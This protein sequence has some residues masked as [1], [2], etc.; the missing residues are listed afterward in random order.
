V[1]A[2]AK[3]IYYLLASMRPQQWTKNLV[4]FAGLIFSRNFR[5]GVLVLHAVEAFLIFCVLSGVIYIVNDVADVE[6]DRRHPAKR[7]RAL[8]SGRLRASFAVP[9]A[10]VLGGAALY[11]AYRLGAEFLTVA[12]T[13]CALNL[14]YSF[15]LKRLVLLDVVS[16]SL[17]FVLRAIGGVEALRGVD[18]SIAISPWLLICT[19][20]LSLFLAFCKRRHELLTIEDAVNHRESLQE[21]SPAL[22]DQLVSITAGG[23]VLAYAIYT[24]WPETVEKFGT[25]DMVYTVPLV[26]TG[27][28]RY[29]YL[30]YN[31]QK[32][33]NPSDLL[34]HEKFLFVIVALWIV[35]VVAILGGF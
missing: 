30:V 15:G 33:G 20:F 3:Q 10:V 7:H 32:G 23:S 22:L 13:F 34:L 4:V 18:P 5:E 14:L 1:T 26:L 8:A 11:G 35:L 6:K 28:M 25:T 17:S 12:C 27:V 31:K 16:I 19:L 29:L 24:I 21:Y 2:A 9:A